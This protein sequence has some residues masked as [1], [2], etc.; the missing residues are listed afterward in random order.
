MGSRPAGRAGAKT[1]GVPR[2]AEKTPA[3]RRSRRAGV[4]LP[5]DVGAARRPVVA[6][7]VVG[8]AA[9]VAVL[10]LVLSGSPAAVA[11]SNQVS[12]EASLGGAQGGGGGCDPGGTVPAGTTA[13]RLGLGAN[14][15]PRVQVRIESNAGIMSSGERPSGWGIAE[16]VTVPVMRLSSAVPNAS[17]CFKLGPTLEAIEGHGGSIETQGPGGKTM[18]SNSLRIEYLKPGASWWS[19][20]SAVARRFGFGHAPS[21]G[22]PVALG[23]LL[24][25]GLVAVAVRLVIE[26]V[27]GGAGVPGPEPDENGADSEMPPARSHAPTWAAGLLARI[28]LRRRPGGEGIAR[29]PGRLAVGARL[30]A[31]VFQI[32]RAARLCAIVG[33]LNAA[34]WSLISPPFQVPD[35]PSHFAYAQLLYE[36][37]SLPTSEF[38]DWSEQETVALTQLHHSAV[39]FHA[40]V[41]PIAT[42][43]EQRELAAEV[44]RPLDRVGEGG[45]GVAH[46]E[47]PLYY[48]LQSI[49]LALSSSGSILDQL[50]L[51]RLLSAL[52]AGLTAMFAYLF[53][54]EALPR[55]RWAWSI[56]GLGVACAPLLGFMSGAVN[57]DAMFYAVSTAGFFALARG[58]RRGLTLRLAAC[59]GGVIA[60]GLLTKL[61]FI[62]ETPGMI[63]G[64]LVLGA[65]RA[66]AARRDAIRATGVGLAIAVAPGV[67]YMLDN[68]LRGRALLGSAVQL[69]SPN[70]GH[71]S[72]GT[73]LSYIWQF[74]LPRLP[75]MGTDFHGLTPWHALWFDRWVG[76]YGWLDTPMPL[77][78]D[79]VALGLVA[80][81]VVLAVCAV[82]NLG[83]GRR[84]VS[85]ARL[86][87]LGVYVVIAVGLLVLIGA[88]SYLE[89]PTQAGRYGE[90]RYML[91]LI[92][93]A[94]AV[95]VLSARGAGHVGAWLAAHGVRGASWRWGPIAGA[96]IVV[97]AIGWDLFSQLQT[98]ARFYG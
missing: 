78:L 53:V 87:E 50:E 70:G 71:G 69:Q 94:A 17:I 39:R 75:G 32:P 11:G 37:H 24:M 18:R 46:S 66:R 86:T 27:A 90:P 49:P 97:L 1:K 38:T 14:V 89:F 23:L 59:I 5:V 45:A 36:S 65:R 30:R 25:L 85:A 96:A 61:N 26:S 88:A 84:R 47:P 4:A 10:A 72:L 9:L 83:S 48:A 64:L 22:W 8:L 62:G 92:A 56:G 35:E 58:F 7:V 44:A 3:P 54:R 2:A 31:L 67:L 51:M 79:N 76:L 41:L 77:W 80:A 28:P 91:P 29:K 55:M 33:V 93:L 63:L 95:A 82:L 34:C 57:P 60:L 12:D 20:L 98:I 21:G 6:A 15:G 74:Y 40:E 16:T 68:L 73:E 81:G 19:Q 52:F 13:V 43:A 42:E